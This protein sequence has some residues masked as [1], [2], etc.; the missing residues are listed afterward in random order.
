L[1]QGDSGRPALKTENYVK[2][3]QG[4]RQRPW[5]KRKEGFSYDDGQGAD[6]Q[7]RVYICDKRW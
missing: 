6:V 5:K 2:K 3:E 7:G 4:S 1:L